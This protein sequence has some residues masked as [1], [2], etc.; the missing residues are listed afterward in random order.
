MKISLYKYLMS[1]LLGMLLFSC[2]TKTPETIRIGVLNGPSAVSFIQMID[3]S[4]VIQGKKVQIM[5]KSEPM[6]IQALMMQG[7]LD[8]AILPTVM[9]A[10]LY[11]KGVN[12]RMLA[13]PVWGTLYLLTNTSARSIKAV[14]NQTV[15]VFGQGLTSDVL[16]QRMLKQN[17]IDKVKI[18]YKSTTN[19]ETAQALLLRK[20]N[21]AVVSEPLVSALMAKDSSIHIVTK[22]YCEDF[23]LNSDKN[24]F[25]Q[26]AFLVSDRFTTDNP[27]LVSAVCEAYSTS[28][29][30]INEQPEK[31]AGLLVKHKLSPNI[32]LAQ[33]SIP[34]CNINYVAAFTIDDE[35]NSYLR[36]FYTFNPKSVSGKIPDNEFIYKKPLVP[37]AE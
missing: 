23:L 11:N 3:Q 27:E 9:A 29:N 35:I 4:P 31:A 34:L 19:N 17:K 10:N 13:C 7:K 21:F 25:V 22:L 18:D 20:T 32:A 30:F 6:Q 15:S 5:L 12:Y 2:S 36:I 24:V 26:T 28:C 8:F 1:V 37:G 14:N 33:R 16:L